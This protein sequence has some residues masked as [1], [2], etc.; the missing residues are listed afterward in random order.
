MVFSN[1][2]VE[3]ILIQEMRARGTDALPWNFSG[4]GSNDPGHRREG[5]EPAKFDLL[6]PVNLD[7]P[8]GKISVL[9]ILNL[10]KRKLTYLCVP[11]TQ[12]R[13]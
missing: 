9:E 11:K 3:T 2:D 8:L 12:I 10:L 5:Q 6:Y 7:R 13:T 1:F 4:F